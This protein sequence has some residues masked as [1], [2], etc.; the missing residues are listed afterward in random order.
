MLLQGCNRK[1]ANMVQRTEELPLHNSATHNT[2]PPSLP[3]ASPVLFYEIGFSGVFILKMLLALSAFVH[4]CIKVR[5]H[6]NARE[7]MWSAQNLSSLYIG[8]IQK[9]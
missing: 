3:T 8:A 1:L 2:H 6:S 9:F 7:G 5:P 4:I